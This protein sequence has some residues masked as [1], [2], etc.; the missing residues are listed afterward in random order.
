[1][2]TKISKIYIVVASLVILA[3][4]AA[5]FGW[6]VTQPPPITQPSP[7]G[8]EVNTP[9][10]TEVKEGGTLFTV[11]PQGSEA[12]YRVQEQLAQRDLPNEA[13]G[14]TNNVAGSIVVD[15]N[16]AI[17]P[18]QSRI[19]VD[20]VSLESDSAR[21]DNYV[22]QNT[23][24]TEEYPT[25]EFVVRQAPGLPHPLPTSGEAQFQVI[26][27][28]TVH[29]VTR[30]TTWDATGRFDEQGA[31]VTAATPIVLTDFG[32]TPPQVGPVLSIEDEAQLELDLRLKRETAASEA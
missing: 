8:A 30:P 2:R 31:T 29:G 14:T 23:L 26:G 4:G 27:D 25:A 19:T 16:G 13:V 15:Q 17:V 3:L 21:R 18:E 1:M 10:P 6:F 28:L 12:R 24:Q 32:M 7:N 5:A 9:L 11:A 20:M 22:R